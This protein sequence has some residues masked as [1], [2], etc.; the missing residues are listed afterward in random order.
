MQ[1]VAAV[2]GGQKLAG[3]LRPKHPDVLAIE[4]NHAA[5]LENLGHTA[6]AAHLRSRVV[7]DMELTLGHQ[8]FNTRAARQSQRLDWDLEP[9]PI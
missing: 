6:E 2:V 7:A 5:T 1:V 8:H 9:Q 4:S 3:V